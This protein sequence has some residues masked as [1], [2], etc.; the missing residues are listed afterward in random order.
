MND[1]LTALA[2]ETQQKHAALIDQ[3]SKYSTTEARREVRD[4]LDA[5][6]QDFTGRALL[7]TGVAAPYLW[8]AANPEHAQALAVRDDIADTE[9]RL[10]R[11]ANGE[12]FQKSVAASAAG[13]YSVFGGNRKGGKDPIAMGLGVLG[14]ILILVAIL[15][16]KR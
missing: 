14:A 2:E 7:L 13:G 15:V 6:R 12:A 3:A 4:E 5:L 9:E 1:E 8:Q 16:V 10:S 11:L